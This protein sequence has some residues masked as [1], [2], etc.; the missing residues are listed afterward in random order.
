[1]NID[2]EKYAF[3]K[4]NFYIMFAGIGL[5]LLGYIIMSMDNTT[6]GFG[7]MGITLGPIILFLGFM[8]QFVA[9]LYKPKNKEKE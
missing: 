6:F 3:G 4:E 2:K 1:M 5:I 7:F 8:V 9:L